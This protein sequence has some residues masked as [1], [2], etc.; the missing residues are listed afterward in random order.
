M[1]ED[2]LAL[3]LLAGKFDG[4]KNIELILQGDKLVF[5][6]RKRAGKNA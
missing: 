5:K 4:A 2:P 1:V 3:D 6:S